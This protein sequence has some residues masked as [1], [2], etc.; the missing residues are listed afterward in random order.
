MFVT[1]LPTIATMVGCNRVVRGPAITYPAGLDPA[2]R[3]RIVE[4]A[5]ALLETEVE[6]GTVVEAS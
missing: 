4:A 5:M 6:P 2:E 1:S 3:R